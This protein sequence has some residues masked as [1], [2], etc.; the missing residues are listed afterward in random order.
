MR[1]Q[2]TMP[3][4]CPT[5]HILPAALLALT[6]KLAPAT[7]AALWEDPLWALS[8]EADVTAGYDS[9][10]FAVNS[11]PSDS[12]ANFKPTL[13]LSRKDSMLSLE[14]EAW[15]DWNTY[16]RETSNDSVDPGFRIKIAYPANVADSAPTQTAELH[17]I[18][19]TDVNFDL[20]E[21]VSQDDALAAYEGT[22]F[23]TG[24]LFVDG[25]A[26]FDHDEY[27]GALFNT[28]DT[29]SIGSTV[30]FAPQPLFKA[31][32]GYD[33]LLG[34][35]VENSGNA[36]ALDKTQQ[37]ITFQ[38]AGEFTPKVTGKISVG[39]AYSDYTGFFSHAQWEAI[40][41][42]DLLWSPTERFAVDLRVSRAPSYNADGDIDV[43]SSVVLEV[44]QKLF[45]GFAVR[46]N[47]QA[48]N[49][50]HEQ[51]VTYRSDATEGAGA[52]LDYNLT[53]RLTTSVDYE[54]TKQG[55]NLSRFTYTRDIVT[56]KL[57]YRF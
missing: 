24:K 37:A 5:Q 39:A 30:S 48:G 31:G 2:S 47:G 57:T 32:I 56:A 45:R 51:V 29:A 38:V 53:G 22:L 25:R 16:L 27:L 49:T 52:G 42:A 12:F 23:D 36:R 18:R 33:L 40:A 41:T 43:S 3:R 8:G 10:L 19:S 46:A 11:G 17:W 9:N 28:I 7:R 21:R 13:L 34:R 6:L 50:D 15:T 44:T 4:R 20:G 26:S 55:S 14:A 54:W 35:S 1:C